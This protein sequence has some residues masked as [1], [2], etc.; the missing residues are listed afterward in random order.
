MFTDS[1]EL[2]VLEG[3]EIYEGERL[4]IDIG[5]GLGERYDFYVAANERIVGLQAKLV[6]PIKKPGLLSHVQFLIAYEK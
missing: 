4:V 5:A 2:Q 3:L 6:D 1:N